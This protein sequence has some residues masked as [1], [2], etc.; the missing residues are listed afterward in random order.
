MYSGPTP[1]SS[2]P[3]ALTNNR[4]IFD[5]LPG[6]KITVYCSACDV[7]DPLIRAVEYLINEDGGVYLVSYYGMIERGRVAV[8]RIW[9]GSAWK[10][11][12]RN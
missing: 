9:T 5:A 2:D 6:A 7:V 8:V 1:P 11:M 10:R 12:C 4:I 3:I